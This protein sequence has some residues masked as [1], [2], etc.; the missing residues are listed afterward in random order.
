M[1]DKVIKKEQL[2]R[3]LM[4][5]CLVKGEFRLRSGIVANEYFDK[6][7]FEA[8]PDLLHATAL[9]L[10]TLIPDNTQ[11]L[12]GLE[13]GGVPLVTA[14]SQITR[15]P[16]LFVRK[17]AKE[18]GTRRLVEGGEVNGKRI[19]V[20]EDVVTSGGQVVQSSKQLRELGAVIDCVVCVI[21]REAGG[22]ESLESE[23]F[24]FRSLFKFSD[25]QSSYEADAS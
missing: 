19:V 3:K 7:Q 21:D 11:A 18:Y 16:A 25:L 14:L 22:K 23:G 6:Y 10:S 20:V 13:L 12:A 5:T 1:V 24:Y 4:R 2:G 15:I 9:E 17:A 8:D